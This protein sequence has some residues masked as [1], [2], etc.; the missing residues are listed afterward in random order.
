MLMDN[1]KLQK[2]FD[3]K[4]LRKFISMMIK[5]QRNS[6]KFYNSLTLNFCELD[7]VE[8]EDICEHNW[9]V[10]IMMEEIESITFFMTGLTQQELRNFMS[11]Q[12]VELYYLKQVPKWKICIDYHIGVSTLNLLLKDGKR[13]LKN[14]IVET[15]EEEF[16]KNKLD[17]DKN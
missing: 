8:V 5:N 14:I 4:N 9:K 13:Y 1:E 2:L 6:G 12:L 15:D 17:Y 10:D 16:I 11:V 7:G 3:D